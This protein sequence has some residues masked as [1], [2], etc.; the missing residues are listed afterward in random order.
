MVYLLGGLE[1]EIWLSTHV[2]Q[3]F[4]CDQRFESRAKYDCLFPNMNKCAS[5]VVQQFFQL[6]TL[7]SM[8]IRVKTAS[9]EMDI[10]FNIVE[11][12]S[13]CF[14][15]WIPNWSE[16]EDQKFSFVWSCSTHVLKPFPRRP[17]NQRLFRQRAICDY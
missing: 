9:S 7:F 4:F 12:T 3:K 17:L 15:V 13:F 6:Q 10:F 1:K 14:E 16:T 2:E 11:N 8:P 5:I